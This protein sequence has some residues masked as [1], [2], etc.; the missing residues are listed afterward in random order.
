MLD[1]ST[2]GFTSEAVFC[3]VVRGGRQGLW[4]RK[5]V[6][7]RILIG[8]KKKNLSAEQYATECLKSD[9]EEDE[10]LVYSK[11][12]LFEELRQLEEDVVAGKLPVYDDLDEAFKSLGI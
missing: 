1:R 9:F 2:A 5:K 4:R 11:E 10:D 12:E 3:W 6:Y 7:D 8:A